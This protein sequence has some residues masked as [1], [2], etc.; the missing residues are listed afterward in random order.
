L[1]L[2]FQTLCLI[3]LKELDIVYNNI[4]CDVCF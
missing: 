1:H 4:R 3:E 2:L